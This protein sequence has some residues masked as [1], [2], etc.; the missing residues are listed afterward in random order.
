MLAILGFIMGVE[1]W[2][3]DDGWSSIGHVR[4]QRER[5]NFPEEFDPILLGF[6]LSWRGVGSIHL[7]EIVRDL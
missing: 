4:V 7:D 2:I 6:L 3:V 1:N 5:N